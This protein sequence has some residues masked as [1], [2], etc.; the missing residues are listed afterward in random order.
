MW[1]F[2]WGSWMGMTTA[3]GHALVNGATI[4]IYELILFW[5]NS[6]FPPLWMHIVGLGFIWEGVIGCSLH[7]FGK[8]KLHL[9]GIEA[10]TEGGNDG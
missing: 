1:T 5:V 9:K 8:E 4:K 3:L 2:S 6:Y 7:S 10:V